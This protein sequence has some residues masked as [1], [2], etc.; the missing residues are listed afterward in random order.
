MI[1][2]IWLL[3]RNEACSSRVLLRSVRSRPKRTF[4][5]LMTLKCIH[6][7]KSS[8]FRHYSR[9]VSRSHDASAKLSYLRLNPTAGN[10][11][12]S[13]RMHLLSSEIAETGMTRP[14]SRFH[15]YSRTHVHSRTARLD[16]FVKLFVTQCVRQISFST[17]L[18]ASWESGLLSRHVLDRT[19]RASGS[20]VLLFISR[21]GV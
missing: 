10:N 6:R 4:G 19:Q 21:L 20:M 2:A 3:K 15:E 12:R 7:C 16:W 13:L 14:I 18:L 5:I 17:L 11:I 1:W 8:C 9:C